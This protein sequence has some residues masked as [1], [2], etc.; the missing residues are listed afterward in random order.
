LIAAGVLAVLFIWGVLFYLDISTRHGEKI[1]VPNLEKYSLEE[2]E[3][4]L[5]ELNLRF[6]VVDSASFNPDFPPFSVVEQRPK[7]GDFV[8]ENRKIYL[9]LNTSKYQSI[10]MPDVVGKTKRQVISTLKASGF[11]IG[12][13]LFIRD[14]GFEVVRGLRFNGKRVRRGDLVPKYSEIDLVLG[15]GKG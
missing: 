6:E 5:G 7:A 11:K 4:R 9:T 2:V 14:P 3:T 12:D 1:L 10:P 13:E 15:D 8:K